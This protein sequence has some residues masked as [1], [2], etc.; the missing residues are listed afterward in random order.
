M[1]V[2]ATLFFETATSLVTDKE[3]VDPLFPDRLVPVW[4]LT[5]DLGMDYHFV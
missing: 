5:S 4:L 3:G 2:V 1:P